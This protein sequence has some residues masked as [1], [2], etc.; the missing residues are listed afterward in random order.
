MV[1]D[2]DYRRLF[3]LKTS[4]SSADDF[5]FNVQQNMRTYSKTSARI[6]HLT[7]VTTHCLYIT[8]AYLGKATFF[9]TIANFVPLPTTMKA[10]TAILI[11]RPPAARG[12]TVTA[13][14]NSAP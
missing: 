9:S 3:T 1:Q 13:L 14:T 11:E 7:I 6:N 12:R 5:T 4:Q 10:A 2:I 8:L